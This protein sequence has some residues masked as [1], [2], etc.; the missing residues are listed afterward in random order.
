MLPLDG[1]RV[2]AVEHYAAGPYGTLQLADLG[3]EVIKIEN[4]A[5][6]GDPIRQMGP[7]GDLGNL[8]SLSF[9]AFNRNKRSLTL[10]LKVDKGKEIFGKLVSTA[11]ALLCNLR[12]DQPEKLGLTYDQLKGHNPKIV[13]GLI[14]AY[15]R[16]G[17]RRDWPGFDYL[18][19][20]E[21]GYLFMSGEP[22]G[23]PTRMGLSI[24]DHLAG[25]TTSLALV[26]SIMK[27]RET[28]E[29]RDID[30][31][32]FDVAAHQLSYVGAWYLNEGIETSRSPRSAHPSVTPSQLFKT[33]DGWLFVMAQ[34]D[35]FWEIFCERIGA[36]ELVGRKEFQTGQARRENRDLLTE[37]LDAHLS[38]Q[39]TAH[40]V[41]ILGGN[42]PCAPV[43][44]IAD[45]LENPFL[46]DREAVV[47]TTHPNRPDLKNLQS[48]V[49][50][51]D[52]I[53]NQPGP[54]LGADTNDI[55]LELG[56]DDTAIQ[57]LRRTGVT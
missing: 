40:W 5:Q 34:T 28:G 43:Y 57:N 52:P 53:P 32:L 11:D 35:R 21:T 38:T 17:P 42:V 29:G 55:L 56:Y 13:C 19:Q 50:M 31:A 18:M 41:G 51:A 39:S 8:D 10:D 2:L 30:V 25:L 12:G 15:G 48:P 36:Q 24:I 44:G 7:G 14:S 47:T 33:G 26:S 54:C 27:S 9:Q 1:V 16:D 37:M 4:R 46:L 6:N 49:R 45:A 3:A 22:G 20:A 23:P